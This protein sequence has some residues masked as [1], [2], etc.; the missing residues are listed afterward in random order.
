MGK[1][2]CLGSLQDWV[3]ATQTWGGAGGIGLQGW[4]GATGKAPVS[5]G[6]GRAGEKEKGPRPTG[7]AAV[8]GA[9]EAVLASSGVICNDL[10]TRAIF[11]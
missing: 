3:G 8:L 10:L 11:R 5:A 2:G 1:G 7:G 4:A 6:A 9:K